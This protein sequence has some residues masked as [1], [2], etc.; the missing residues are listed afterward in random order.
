MTPF[1]PRVMTRVGKLPGLRGNNSEQ[2]RR[3]PKEAGVACDR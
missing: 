3:K 1:C 2:M